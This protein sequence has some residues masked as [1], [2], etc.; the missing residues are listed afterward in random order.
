MSNYLTVQSVLGELN[1]PEVNSIDLNGLGG[2]ATIT[3]DAID[4]GDVYIWNV[5]ANM[6]DLRPRICVPA[7][8]RDVKPRC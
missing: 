3:M 1:S 8:T 6:Q 5:I 2:K 4:D 7:E